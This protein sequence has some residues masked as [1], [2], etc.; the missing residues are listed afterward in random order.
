MQI[1]RYMEEFKSGTI[2]ALKTAAQVSTP[3]RISDIH[4]ALERRENNLVVAVGFTIYEAAILNRTV[5]NDISLEGEL[6]QVEL[7]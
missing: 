7:I 1:G 6:H 4:L 2:L 3:L 5:A